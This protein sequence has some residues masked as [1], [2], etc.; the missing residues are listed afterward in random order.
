MPLLT[1]I[2]LAAWGEPS[3]PQHGSLHSAAAS[4]TPAG[5][6]AA[7]GSAEGLTAVAARPSAPLQ[8]HRRRLQTTC[9][10]QGLKQ[11]NADW[12]CPTGMQMPT[13]YQWAQVQPCVPT[14]GSYTYDGTYNL[15][16]A[17]YVGGCGCDWND[18]WCGQAVGRSGARTLDWQAI[19]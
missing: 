1:A 13:E 19:A 6:K 9:E 2:V 3:A 7:G 14:D 4:S 10:Y 12:A 17:Y 5:G 11:G 15:G 8:P 18:N 16:V